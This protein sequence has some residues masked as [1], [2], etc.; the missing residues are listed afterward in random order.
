MA[1]QTVEE[2]K[3]IIEEARKAHGVAMGAQVRGSGAQR[4]RRK[5]EC[6]TGGLE[7]RL[8]WE[9]ALLDAALL[10]LELLQ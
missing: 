8:Q 2:I 4:G 3:A 1:L 9:A 5:G 7:G 10:V 6:R